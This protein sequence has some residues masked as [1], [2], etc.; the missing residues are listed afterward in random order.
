ML[1][2]TIK[3]EIRA[4]GDVFEVWYSL[5]GGQTNQFHKSFTSM[6]KAIKETV[7]MKGYRRLLSDLKK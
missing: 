4:N 3:T 1:K 2:T 6:D 7:S 5:D